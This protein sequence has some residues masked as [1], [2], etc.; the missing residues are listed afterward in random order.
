[1]HERSQSI[2]ALTGDERRHSSA[3]SL[4]GASV[5]VA[6]VWR[7]IFDRNGTVGNALSSIGIHTGG[8]TTNPRLSLI[9]IVLLAVWNLPVGHHAHVVPGH[10]VQPGP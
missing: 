5:A 6:L 4:L 2:N 10:P 1:M 8:W 7:T 3:G 9:V